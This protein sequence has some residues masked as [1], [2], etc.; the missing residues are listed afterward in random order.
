MMLEGPET[1]KANV[2]TEQGPQTEVTCLQT[3]HNGG[4]K[5]EQIVRAY[6]SG[7]GLV[8]AKKQ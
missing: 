8:I 1:K 3:E 2:A 7:A 5:L 4:N 6:V